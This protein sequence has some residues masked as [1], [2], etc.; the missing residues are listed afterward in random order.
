MSSNERNIEIVEKYQAALKADDRKAGRDLA[1]Q[2]VTENAGL[3]KT[4]GFRYGKPQT[5]AD[6]DDVLQAAQ[7]GLLRA[8]RDFDPEKGSFST[9]AAWHIR[10]YVQRWTGKT[11]A[12]VRPKSAKMPASVA[13]AMSKF[14]LMH[15][16]EPSAEDLGITQAQLDEWSS[17][18][19]FVEVD[20]CDEERPIV[21]LTYDADEA[22]TQA[23]VMQLEAAW[24]KAL[25]D[26]SPRNRDIAERVLMK[27]E[28]TVVVAE[29]LGLTHGRVIQVCKRIEFRLKKSLN[30]EACDPSEDPDR[31]R[32]HRERLRY[33]AAATPSYAAKRLIQEAM[34]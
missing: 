22:D 3:A 16:R 33:A 1:E 29:S 27:G 28:S 5:E 17:A 8:A 2:I 18:T 30:P 7:M 11:S 23:R 21:E 12:I 19:H 26:L 10:D 32:A 6:E 9:H 24:G 31:K 34:A 4:F 14:R 13:K 15:G 20:D 25:G